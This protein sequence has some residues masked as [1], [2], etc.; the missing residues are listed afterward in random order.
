MSPRVAAPVAV[1]VGIVEI[2]MSFRTFC[3]NLAQSL[4]L[5]PGTGKIGTPTTARVLA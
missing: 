2:D 1:R 3:Q 5:T 4:T